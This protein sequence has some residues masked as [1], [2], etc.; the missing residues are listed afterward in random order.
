MSALNRVTYKCILVIIIIM[1]VLQLQ[2]N[3]N[4]RYKDRYFKHVLLL[5]LVNLH[6]CIL[7]QEYALRYALEDVRALMA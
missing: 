6:A 2:I 1:I 7:I 3:Q 5:Y 4:A